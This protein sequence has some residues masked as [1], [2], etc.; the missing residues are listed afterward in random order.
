MSV[1]EVSFQYE[2]TKEGEDRQGDFIPVEPKHKHR[3][4]IW[5]DEVVAREKVRSTLIL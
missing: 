1:G 2:R 3:F 4:E 5:Q